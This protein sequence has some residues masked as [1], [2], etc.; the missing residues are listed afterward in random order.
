DVHA[1]GLELGRSFVQPRYW[2]KR[3]LEY[4]WQGIGALLKVRPQYR[5][6]FGSVS[7]SNALPDLAK[8][9]L[10][11]FYQHHFPARQPLAVAH[12]PY[13]PTSQNFTLSG[14]FKSDFNNLKSYLASMNCNVPTLYKQYSDLCEPGGV[15]FLEFGVDPDFANAIDGLVLVDIHQLKA[16]KRKKYLGG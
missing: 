10:V 2:G 6:L 12:H 3:S 8:D 14:C 1:E 15:Q 7:I 9:A 4:L 13:Q 11:A 5:Y 16:K